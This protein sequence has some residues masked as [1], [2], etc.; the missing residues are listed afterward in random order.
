MNIRLFSLAFLI[1]TSSSSLSFAGP[2]ETLALAEKVVDAGGIKD[3]M[4]DNFMGTIEAAM[5]QLR[6]TGGE[7]LTRKV[8]DV[9]RVFFKENYKWETLRVTYAEAYAA[10][11]T[12]EELTA[13]LA[14]YESAVGKKFIAKNSTINRTVSQAVNVKMQ[15]KMPALQAAMMDAV[16]KHMESKQGAKP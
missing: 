12:D 11:F 16:K 6:K 15:D 9:A 3:G 5:A 7:E 8:T 13:L 2:A 4:E 1:V 10:E 14:F